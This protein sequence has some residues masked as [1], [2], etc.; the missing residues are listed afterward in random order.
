MALKVPKVK[1]P[2]GGDPRVLGDVGPGAITQ[3]PQMDLSFLNDLAAQQQAPVDGGGFDGG[4]FAPAPAP[5][6]GADPGWI[7]L[8]AELD[9]ENAMNQAEGVRRQGQI[10]SQRDRLLSDLVPQGEAQR[11]TISGG[12]E[13]RGLYGGG[14]MEESLARQRANEGRRQTGIQAD[15]YSGLSD[16]AAQQAMQQQAIEGK[17]AQARADYMSRGYTA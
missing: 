6:L 7:A 16:L 5:S 17:R 10:V 4:G 9:Q 11:T 2:G 12:M 13:S 3:A 15:A 8:Q 14:Q 1:A